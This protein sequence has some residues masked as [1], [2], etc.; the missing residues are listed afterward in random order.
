MSGEWGF[1]IA[2]D[3]PQVNAMAKKVPLM[4][5]RAGSPKEILDTPREV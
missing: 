1:I 2:A 5:S 3:N 4:A